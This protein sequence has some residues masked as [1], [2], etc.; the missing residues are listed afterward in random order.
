MSKLTPGRSARTAPRRRAPDSEDSLRLSGRSA[1]APDAGSEAHPGGPAVADPFEERE[2]VRP[3][4]VAA[5][6]FQRS[7]LALRLAASLL[8]CS[9][10]L[11]DLG[12]EVLLLNDSPEDAELSSALASLLPRLRAAFPCRVEKAER[13]LGFV[14]TANR[15]LA[16][17]LARGFDAVLLNSDTV[18]TPGALS[19]MARV[20]RLDPMIGFVNPRSNNATLATLPY[21]DRFRQLA[22]AEARA[23]WAQLAP[24]LPEL[25]YVPTTVGF[26][27]LIRWTVLAQFGL[28]DEIF[29]RGY[30]EENDLAMRAGRRG[31]RAVLAN[32]AFVWHEGG[33]SFD[34][35]ASSTLEARNRAI[36]LRR[37][38]EYPGL[39]RSYFTSAE[40]RAELLLGAIIPDA[41]GRVD[42]ALDF[43]SFLPAYNGTFAAG[44]QLLEK[45]APLWRD[46]FNLHV[47]CSE[48]VY[49]FHDL[50]RF[51]A[52][53]RDPH[54]PEVFAAVFRVGQPYDA[55]AVQRLVLKGA[56]V[57]VYMLDTISMDCTQLADPGVVKLWA[58]VCEHA[59]LV[60]STSRL[61]FDQLERRFRFGPEVRHVRSLHSLDLADYAPGPAGNEPPEPGPGHL[62]VI[63]NH[64][65]HK[66][67][68]P[69][70]NALAGA[71]P[72]RTVVVLGGAE[73][74]EAEASDAGTYPPPR[75]EDRPNLTAL[76]AGALTPAQV[77]AL[78]AEACAVVVPSH[79]EGFGMPV[80]NALAA[81]RPVL[82]RPLPVFRELCE[83]L[84]G[85]ANLHAFLTLDEL[86]ALAADPP[87]W[88]DEGASPGVPGDGARMARE[89]GAALDAAIAGVDYA[90]IV[91]RI[92]TVPGAAP[93]MPAA[94]APATPE[95]FVAR[96]VAQRVERWTEAAVSLPGLMPALRAAVRA[97]RRLFGR[98]R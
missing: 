90:R 98:R 69:A 50:Q 71:D 39:T 80:L 3:L 27:A 1:R 33:G 25:S 23:A 63:G 40:Q 11:R 29:G 91:R 55:G 42:V 6:L 97:A 34:S 30:N 38:P 60:A 96:A 24:K 86:V 49:A 43:S 10:E 57:G 95:A 83:R 81:R 28:L 35:A 47:L 65:A 52:P 75:L 22:P 61:T 56:A 70:A 72:G 84:G 73:S 93:T 7:D 51:G 12:A 67:V 77:A 66:D 45:A 53:R 44:V 48:E 37:Y 19:E 26:C 78:Y 14:R 92:A 17:A 5:P 64:Y 16:E 76:K 62:L 20:S 85:E 87:A 36:L 89:I 4:L 46:R 74:S 2:R 54:G 13:N 79:Y 94:P 9:Q 32:H 8:D 15:G 41:D 18:L 59:D 82:V 88:S 31:Y 58:F 68:A 21:Q